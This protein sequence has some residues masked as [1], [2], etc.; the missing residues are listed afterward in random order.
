[1]VNNL[2]FRWPKHLFFMV[3]GAHGVYTTFTMNINH[4]C[5]QIKAVPWIL[6]EF[7]LGIMGFWGSQRSD[8]VTIGQ[9]DVSQ[10]A[11][12]KNVL[13]ELLLPNMYTP[14]V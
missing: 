7:L 4:S 10:G 1:M 11:L 14:K 9:H 2:V 13:N 3:L 6:W 8:C 12:W 5:R